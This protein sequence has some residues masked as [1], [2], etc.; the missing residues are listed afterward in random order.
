MDIRRRNSV[1][2][3]PDV[4][5]IAYATICHP[6]VTGDEVV[7]APVGEGSDGGV[8]DETVGPY[9]GCVGFNRARIKLVI[10]T[11]Q[12]AHVAV[13]GI[14]QIAV[15]AVAGGGI[16][17]TPAVVTSP[18]EGGIVEVQPGDDPEYAA[19]D[20][21]AGAIGVVIRMVV[22]RLRLFGPACGFA[23]TGTDRSSAIGAQIADE[24]AVP[25]VAGVDGVRA[26]LRSR[27]GRS[28]SDDTADQATDQCASFVVVVRREPVAPNIPRQHDTAAAGV[29]TLDS[30]RLAGE[31]TRSAVGTQNGLPPDESLRLSGSARYLQI[32]DQTARRDRPFRRRQSVA[33]RRAVFVHDRHARVLGITVVQSARQIPDQTADVGVLRF[34]SRYFLGIF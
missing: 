13:P 12:D 22:R 23:G 33:L 8:F 26:V 21:Y 25:R 1:S 28:R 14:G 6:A 17:V 27:I 10:D 32:T 9:P 30:G 11:A 4:G 31:I 18:S 16:A 20:F 3:E 2:G 24:V 7:V 5:H 34:Q 29:A 15:P 19:L